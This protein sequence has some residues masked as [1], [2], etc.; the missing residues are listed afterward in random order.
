MR[1]LTVVQTLNSNECTYI[2]QL[3]KLNKTYY[4]KNGIKSVL[5]VIILKFV[6]KKATQN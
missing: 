5:H 1:I 4:R 3:L 6:Y 2:K